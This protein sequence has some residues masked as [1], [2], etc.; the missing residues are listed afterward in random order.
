MEKNE[1]ARKV[2]LR[3]ERKEDY[4]F[5]RRV[6]GHTR[7]RERAFTNATE[8]Q[9]EEFLDQQFA[10]Q[11]EYYHSNYPGASYAVILFEKKEPIGRLY[12]HERETEHR[13]ID[14]ALLSNWQK[15]GIGG[16]LMKRV[17]N[18]AGKAGK[19]VSIHVEQYNPAMKLY[20][21]LGFQ[22]VEDNGVYHLMEW[23]PDREE[24]PRESE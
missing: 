7:A 2:S 3:P 14:I 19:G 12:V 18:A 10:A 8:A 21:R 16:Y 15:K 9:F 1:I 20:Q 24:P 6:Y 13:V 4:G 11:Y 17:L 23:K 5:L 22:H